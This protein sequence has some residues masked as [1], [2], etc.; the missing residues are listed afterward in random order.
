MTTPALISCPPFQISTTF[1]DLH[2]TPQ[3]MVAKGVIQEI[4]E[5]K[6]ARE[7]MYW[8]VRRR[9]LEAEVEGRIKSANK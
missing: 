5:W 2:D 7:F 6:T 1:A 4:L 3:R 9:M 8:K